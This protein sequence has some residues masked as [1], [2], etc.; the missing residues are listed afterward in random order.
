MQIK[1]NDVCLRASLGYDPCRRV[2]PGGQGVKIRTKRRIDPLSRYHSNMRPSQSR[3]RPL[4]VESPGRTYSIVRVTITLMTEPQLRWVTVGPTGP[5]Q[6]T[7]CLLNDMPPECAILIFSFSLSCFLQFWWLG[8]FRTGL[9]V[10]SLVKRYL[11]S[12]QLFLRI[13]LS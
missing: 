12:F 5:Q 2:G 9:R 1:R 8:L 7:N 4:L 10:L 6:N 13:M 11:E 3:R